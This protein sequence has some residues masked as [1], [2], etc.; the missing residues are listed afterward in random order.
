MKWFIK[1]LKQYADFGGRARRKEY[2]WFALIN[3]I[4]S[5]ILLI[6]WVTPIVKMGFDAAA[7]GIDDVDEMDIVITMLKSP[8]LYIYLVYYL[9][10]LIPGISVTVRRLHDIGRSGYW[11]FFIFGG[12]MLGSLSSYYQSTNTALFAVLSLVCFIVCIISLVWMFT[13]SQYGPN[14]YGP[15]PKGEGNSTEQTNITVS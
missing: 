13:D 3:F 11:A 8:F 12:S 15:N 9:A 1:C 7:A 10:V 14:Q 4:I 5:I 2:W 6:C